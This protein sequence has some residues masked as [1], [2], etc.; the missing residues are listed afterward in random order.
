M[1]QSILE[2]KNVT[3]RFP[4]VL[5]LNDVSISVNKGEI[6]SICGEN[7]AGKSTLMKVLSGSYTSKE[8]E[9]EIWIDGKKMEEMS[10]SVAREHG[11]EMVYQET[12][13]ML[14]GTVEENLY[15]GSLPG[16]KGM[17]D[18][19]TLHRQTQ[20]VLD[21]IDL[22]VKPTDIVRPLNSGQLQMLSIMRAVIRAPK[23]LVLDEPTSALTDVEVEKLFKIM[24]ELKQKGVCCI[25]ISHKLDEVFKISDRV[26][27]M[28]DG[29]VISVNDI[30]GT[31]YDKLVEEMVGRKMA[32]MYPAQNNSVCPEV[33][34]AVENLSV[35]H[36]TIQGKNIVSDI[37]F[38]LKKGEIL[39]LGGLVGAGRSETLGAIFGQYTKRVT[40]KVFINGQEA[41]IRQPK[42]AIRYGIGFVTEERKKNGFVWVLSVLKNLTLDCFK[43]LPKKY[44][45]Y[46]KKEREKAQEV[47]DRLRIKPPSLDTR[48]I[49]LSG[50]NQQKVVLG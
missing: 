31:S 12:N 7:G 26:I 3:K 44:I 15:V 46:D 48:I 38:Q 24:F 23:I 40:K 8:Y 50:G 20:Q 17:V 41:A 11:I 49:N 6:I 39:G 47:F 22:A 45:I 30:G 35:P 16:K 34:F 33:V 2:M 10:V 5:A 13:A 42:D 1:L 14:D 19:K 29:A 43:E 9:G 37:S 27:V 18:Y 28:R 25:Y 32:Q 36:P 21:Q 4:G